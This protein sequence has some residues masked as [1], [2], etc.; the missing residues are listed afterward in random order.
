MRNAKLMTGVAVA[1]LIAGA[2]GAFAQSKADIADGG[3]V[4]Q[5][6]DN[7]ARINNSATITVGNVSGA[8]ASEAASATGALSSVSGSFT[9]GVINIDVGDVTQRTDQNPAAVSDPTPEIGNTGDLQFGNISGNGASVSS[10]ATAAVSAVSASFIQAGGD[11]D[12]Q[13][14]K[15]VTT[16]STNRRVENSGTLDA[17]NTVVSGDGASLSGSATGASSV[18]S[19]SGIGQN[20]GVSLDDVRIDSV[21]Q[22]TNS[23]AQVQQK[24]SVTGNADGGLNEV[25]G[26]GASASLSASGAQSA[27]AVSRIGGAASSKVTN[28]GEIDQT[29][30]NEGAA[31]G[32]SQTGNFVNKFDDSAGLDGGITGN[33]ASVSASATGAV[34]SVSVS[35]INTLGSSD[36]D[37]ATGTSIDQD[38]TNTGPADFEPSVENNSSINGTGNVSGLGASAS[39]SSTGA[40]AAV[41][42]SSI[43]DAQAPTTNIGNVRQD[44]INDGVITTSGTIGSEAALGN[45]SGKGASV[46]ISSTGAIASL[47]VSSINSGTGSTA[48]GNI[49]QTATNTG[50]VSTTGTISAGNLSGAGASASVS[51]T[52]AASAASVSTIN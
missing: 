50:N 41:S 17:Q 29:T 34:S 23:D 26:A 8:G 37:I 21:D 36:I 7:T 20:A 30:T 11:V 51:T 9:N 39:L 4:V 31:A 49:N 6:T 22:D 28:I 25:S 33:G 35:S 14:I 48:T 10:S 16:A 44:A 18:V 40:V 47:S 27:V 32:I 15:Q 24:S 52:G 45:I 2:P 3:N 38:S 19:I 42:V 13:D 43:N 12:I 5:D 1:A 46:S